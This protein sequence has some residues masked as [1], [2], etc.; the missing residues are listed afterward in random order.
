MQLAGFCYCSEG[1][2]AQF[3]DSIEQCITMRQRAFK[4]TPNQ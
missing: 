3:A 1:L 4:Y 2:A